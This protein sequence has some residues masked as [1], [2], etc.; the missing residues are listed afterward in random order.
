MAVKKRPWKMGGVVRKQTMH[1]LLTD[2]CKRARARREVPTVKAVRAILNETGYDSAVI[3][4]FLDD[5]GLAG[6][7]GDERLRARVGVYP[8]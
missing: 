8:E 3:N 5:Q 7:Y 1:E 6:A 2:Y 4:G